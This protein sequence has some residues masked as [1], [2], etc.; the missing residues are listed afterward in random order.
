MKFEI[1][2]PTIKEMHNQAK[3]IY[4]FIIFVSIVII[5]VFSYITYLTYNMSIGTYYFFNCTILTLLPVLVATPSLIMTL[6]LGKDKF[7]EIYK[8][9]QE[10]LY[11]RLKKFYHIK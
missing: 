4:H 5:P 8:K 6:Y 10:D 9:E 11:R 3:V 7:Y 1:R 2:K